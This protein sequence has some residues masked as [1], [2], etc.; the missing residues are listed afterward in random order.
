[1]KQ[2]RNGWTM[3]VTEFAAA[4]TGTIVAWDTD[5]AKLIV[6]PVY[7]GADDKWSF[8]CVRLKP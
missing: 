5:N 3:K 4:I 6:I 2:A 8:G 1:M 7:M